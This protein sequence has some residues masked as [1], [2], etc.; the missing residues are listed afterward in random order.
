MGRNERLRII[1]EIEQK[2]G[3][4]K[5]VCYLTSDRQ[6]AAAMMNKDILPLFASHLRT[7]G[8]H[9]KIDVFIFTHGG[10]TLCGFG[11]ARLIREYSDSVGVLVPDACHSAG[12]LFA[13]GANEII[14][15]RGATLSPI[16]PSVNG[17]L[18]P[19]V[20]INPQMPPQIVP[21]S[22]ESVAGYK[23]L[24][25][26]EWKTDAGP[27]LKILAEK[28]HPLALGDIY[29]GR[30]QIEMLALR[31]LEQHRRDRKNIRKIIRTLSK[32]LGSHDYLL[33]PSE[34][35]R[36]L[37]D[38]VKK[39]ADL[40]RLILALH[41]DYQKELQL[42][43]PYSGEVLFTQARSRPLAAQLAA[44]GN[45]QT[46]QTIANQSAQDAQQAQ[47]RALSAQGSP[48]HATLTAASLE[49]AQ[50]AMT[51]K[52][53]ADQAAIA[54]TVVQQQVPQSVTAE[55]KLVLIESSSFTDVAIQ[56]REI[57][58]IQLPTM[59]GMPQNRQVVE[60]IV[61]AGWERQA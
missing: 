29:R 10:D 56:R 55:L 34:A 13:L 54:L 3:G 43:I 57:A 17:P 33:Y 59:P 19:A 6:N 23:S 26:K 5:L 16:D 14:M 25:S 30:Q 41:E 46:L 18:N 4:S 31:L 51:A 40:E 42:G 28:V 38:Q 60:R 8:M 22:V 9:K 50:R 35:H 49:A 37:G 20:Q 7:D 12:T 48:D 44:A 36:L 27:L 32:D 45:L 58:E 24:I 1:R 53:A 21:L 11:L 52:A 61:F 39:D 2:R 15:T 47:Q